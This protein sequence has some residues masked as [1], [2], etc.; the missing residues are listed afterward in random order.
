MAGKRRL[1]KLVVERALAPSRERARS[2]I[3][4][5]LVR[6]D[7]RP[8]LKAGASFSESASISLK[9]AAHPYVSRGGVKLAG[10]LDAF[11]IH[12]RG[13]YCLD[14]GAST[15]GFTDALLRRGA[16]RVA[17]VDVGRGLIDWKLRNDPRVTL[18][19]GVNARHL[20][21][22]AFRAAAGEEKP[23]LCAVDVSFISVLK[24]LAPVR[25]L[26]G[27][28]GE[29][30]ALVKPQFEA[31]RGRVGKGGIVRDPALHRE[32]LLRVWDEALRM[33]LAPRGVVPSAIPGAKGNRE[34][35]LHLRPGAE[36]PRA[37]GLIEDALAP[38]PEG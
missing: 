28:G 20:T 30:A 12:P 13:R 4:A 22:E 21:P 33:R 19:E 32:V 5:G 10:A 9:E 27:G 24:V 3:L 7:G 34:F 15:G 18:L 26:L 23:D 25:E 2:L 37:R 11:G 17:S 16:R 35:F 29:I 38:P 1:D 31:G 36:S 6:V 8:A 14:V